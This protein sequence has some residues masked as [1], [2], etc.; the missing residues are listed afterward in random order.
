[1]EYR[2]EIERLGQEVRF[3][4]NTEP[5]SDHIAGNYFFLTV[6]V[7]HQGTLE[8]MQAAS[9]EDLKERFRQIDPD[10]I[11]SLDTYSIRLPNLTFTKSLKLYLGDHEIELL[12]LPGH[13]ATE[14]AVW[15]PRE[16]VIFTGDNIFY[17]TQTYLHEAL[18]REWL[19]S[20]EILRQI[21]ADILIPGHGELCTKEY[22]DEQIGFIKEWVAAIQDAIEK[23]WT[24]EE[25]QER[26]SFL[27]RFPM[28]KDREEFGPQLQK[29]NVARLYYL[30]ET[31][32]L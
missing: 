2:E 27:D 1:M 15:I 3:L 4:I 10:F 19:N 12:H 13:T 26:I 32:Q 25:A 6:G 22:I 20:L 31:G 7:A 11:P 16:R 24:V 23:G 21:D 17:K 18:T 28:P 8:H 9:L 14:T 29:N 5:H 30:A